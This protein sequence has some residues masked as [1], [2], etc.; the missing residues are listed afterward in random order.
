MEWIKDTQKSL[1]EKDNFEKQKR[2]LGIYPV[3][4]ILVSKE[5][6]G[7][8]DLQ[9]EAKCPMILSNK[10]RLMELVMRDCHERVHH[11]GV[12]STLAELRSRV[13]VTKG[14]QHVK[15]VLK[16][17]FK[18]RKY[19]GKPYKP[20]PSAALPEFRVTQAPL[21]DS[22]GTDFAGPFYVKKGGQVSMS[23]L[24][25]FSCCITRSLHLELVKI[26]TT[27]F[28]FLEYHLTRC[29]TSQRSPSSIVYVVL[30]HGETLRRLWCQIMQR[31]LNP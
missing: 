7:N 28:F 26:L 8:S 20:S 3:D 9:L 17:C 22:A 10:D 31:R 27:F 23:D 25:L 30:A 2:S 4:G 6:L 19:E 16:S 18:Y 12:G 14:R 1:T 13:W 21:F 11:G 15:K 5:W 24:A 29:S